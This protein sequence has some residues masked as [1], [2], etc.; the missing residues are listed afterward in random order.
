MPPSTQWQSN[1]EWCAQATPA[2]INV[3]S[4]DAE[5][6]G[7]RSKRLHQE[8]SPGPHAVPND[9]TVGDGLNTAGI[10][11]MRRYYGLDVNTGET[12]DTNNRISSTSGSTTTSIPPTKPVLSRHTRYDFNNTLTAAS[13]SG[14]MATM[15]RRESGRSCTASR[16]YRHI[17]KYRQ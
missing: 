3:F 4:Y 17:F 2:S 8:C 10:R 16:W 13:S 15:A 9:F 1:P 5:S 7:L 6:E 14:R 12:Y 11:F